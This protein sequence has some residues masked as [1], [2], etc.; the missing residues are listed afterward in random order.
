MA[1][2]VDFYFDFSSPY[3][4]FAAAKI[5]EI[6]SRHQRTVNWR[7]F[8]LGAVFKITKMQPLLDYPLKGD[9]MK[10][11]WLRFARLIG[12]KWKL[13]AQFPFSALVPS[14]IFYWLN[15]KDPELARK[16]AKAAYNAAFS[17]GRDVTAIS[18][19]TAIGETLGIA[20]GDMIAASNDQAVKDR[21]RQE[22]EAAIARGVFGS[23]YIVVDGEPFWGA[24]RLDQV[25]GWLATG[26]W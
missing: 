20:P 1:A 10:R 18:A 8:L 26:G 19:L 25:D 7:P 11:D 12:V 22:V 3:G 24:D 2:P 9:Y 6:A 14:R 4:Y 16:F 15:D 17:E 13:P 21:C 23:P 5:D